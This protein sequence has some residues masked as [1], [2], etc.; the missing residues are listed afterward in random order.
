MSYAVGTHIGHVPKWKP[1]SPAAAW[2]MLIFLHKT[3]ARSA[4]VLCKSLESSALPEAE[5][6]VGSMTA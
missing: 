5:S 1:D 4:N 2:Y 6:S 3:F